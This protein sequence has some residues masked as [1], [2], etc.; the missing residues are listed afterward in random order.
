MKCKITTIALNKC[1]CYGLLHMIEVVCTLYIWRWMCNTHVIF[2][3]NEECPPPQNNYCVHWTILTLID[4]YMWKFVES[5]EFIRRVHL[6]QPSN[7]AY[8]YYI[9]ELSFSITLNLLV[10]CS[11]GGVKELFYPISKST[12][13]LSFHLCSCKTP[14]RKLELCYP[15]TLWLWWC[16]LNHAT[17]QLIKSHVLFCMVYVQWLLSQIVGC[18]R[19]NTRWCS[20]MCVGGVIRINSL[21]GHSMMST[22]RV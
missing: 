11:Y 19:I 9:K 14:L 21:H 22:W 1:I 18:K 4:K 8:T 3:F 20:N 7:Y 13:H 10:I 12:M 6:P 2:K 16:A 5:Q 15:F 17:I